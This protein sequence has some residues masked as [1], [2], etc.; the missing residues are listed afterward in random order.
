MSCNVQPSSLD[1]S[2]QTL[3]FHP[4]GSKK[5]NPFA[6]YSKQCQRN[7]LLLKGASTL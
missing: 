6:R 5:W 4:S 3:G 1:Y 2:E 7:V